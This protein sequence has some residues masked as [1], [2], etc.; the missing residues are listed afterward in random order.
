MKEWLTFDPK[1]LRREVELKVVLLSPEPE[2]LLYLLVLFRDHF[3]KYLL[4]EL[5][6][7]V[8]SMSIPLLLVSPELL[9]SFRVCY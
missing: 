2:P 8:V 5:V 7:E 4:D 6:S 3:V 9:D 1:A